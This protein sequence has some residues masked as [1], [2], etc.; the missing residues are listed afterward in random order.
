MNVA[1]ERLNASLADI[2]ASLRRI[3]DVLT[4]R[5]IGTVRTPGADTPPPHPV[6]EWIKNTG[7]RPVGADVVVDLRFQCGEIVPKALAGGWEWK[8]YFGGD[9]IKEWRLPVEDAR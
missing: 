5:E 2:A 7:T 4:E 9:G 6:H 8:I 3:A 1:E